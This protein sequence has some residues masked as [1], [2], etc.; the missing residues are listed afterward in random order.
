MERMAPTNTFNYQV[1]ITV[2]SLNIHCIHDEYVYC[3]NEWSPSEPFPLIRVFEAWS[4]L[5]PPFMVDNIMD[6]LVM[7]KLQKAIADWSRTDPVPLHTLVLP[8][9]PHL[10]LRLNTLL[11]DARRK[12]RSFLRS[13]TVLDGVPPDLLVWKDVSHIC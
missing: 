10:G 13:W 6:Q 5:L 1:S 8:W 7:P 11:D 4:D 2:H 12:L 9:L 3:S